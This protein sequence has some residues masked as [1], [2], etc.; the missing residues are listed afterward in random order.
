MSL[1]MVLA[2]LK[3]FV[4]EVVVGAVNNSRDNK[5]LWSIVF[6]NLEDAI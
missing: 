5:P 4:V 6:A 3:W 1:L 2:S